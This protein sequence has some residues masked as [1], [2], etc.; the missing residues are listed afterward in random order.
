MELT[1]MAEWLNT[2]F[3]G[4]DHAL[5]SA[6]HSLAQAAGG[7]F[8]PLFYGVSLLAEHGI[9][10]LALSL[11]LICFKRTRRVGLCALC[12]VCCGALLTNF[13]LK[14]WI[15]RPRPFIDTAGP[16]HAWWQFV[17]APMV[18]EFSFPSGHTTATMAV[19]TSIFLCCNKKY[20]WIGFLLVL[21]MGASRTYL[22]VHYPSDILGGLL[23]GALGAV[24]AFYLTK[25]LCGRGHGRA[26]TPAAP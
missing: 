25:A 5:L 13:T 21:L 2:V 15:A 18:S 8:T 16:Y 10:M 9:G 26:R 17:G 20:S 12:A 14:L 22:M 4:Y 6:L 23:A 1:Y 11:A 3:A 7:F 24:A 19:M